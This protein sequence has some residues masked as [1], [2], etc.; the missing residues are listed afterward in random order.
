MV[1]FTPGSA[2]LGGVL[3][4]LAVSLFLWA[5]GRVAGI[6]GVVG[7]LLG[8][9]AGDVG[10]RLAFLAG[11]V[12]VGVVAAAVAPDL[13]H[14]SAPRSTAAMIVAGLLVGFGTRLGNGC[15]SGH[16]V[17]GISRLSVRSVVATLTFMAAGIVTVTVV[18]VFFGGSL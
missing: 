12:G 1:N 11:L 3:I 7:G 16:G 6:S 15:T 9:R 5:T 10:W 17:C 8:A 13:V 14:F 4:G 18:R 2:L